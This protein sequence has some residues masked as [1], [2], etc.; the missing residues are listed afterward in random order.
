MP[1]GLSLFRF[2]LFSA[3]ML[4]GVYG[5]ASLYF[6]EPPAPGDIPPHGVPSAQWQPSPL[7]LP[8]YL[9]IELGIG[10]IRTVGRRLW[11]FRGRMGHASYAVSSLMFIAMVLL[12]LMGWFGGE[13]IRQI[14]SAQT[15]RLNFVP[16]WL[17]RLKN[18]LFIVKT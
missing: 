7:W 14:R 1:K 11:C 3:L 17:K 6:N 8:S 9:T 18:A 15:I 2:V 13:A 5:G 12:G 4:G 16:S 10:G